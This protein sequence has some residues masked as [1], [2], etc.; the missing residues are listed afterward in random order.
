MDSESQQNPDWDAIRAK[1]AGAKGKTFWRTL[2]EVA[3]T[4]EFQQVLDDE[5]PD[6]ANLLA[7]MD[8]RQF[9]TL[10]GASLALAGLSGCRVLPQEKAVPSVKA[11]EEYIP[12]QPLA[13]ATAMPLSGYAHPL[14]ITSHDGRPT[15]A[16]GNEMH[17]A[18]MGST[19]IYAQASLIT[20]YDPDRSK[21]VV[22]ENE[23]S[24]WEAFQNAALPIVRAQ[25]ET[26]GSGLHILTET[27]TSP[28]LI[29]QVATL[30][31][32]YPKMQWHTYE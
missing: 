1:L 28:T 29:A 13:F 17:P 16:E 7:Q 27:T 5:F 11:P 6:R 3:D 30:K 14:L 23:I 19:N 12:G 24:G 8:R 31:A 26:E 21:N 25:K 32:L 22:R 4:Q 15:K 20:M 2:D 18:S 10:A 9:L